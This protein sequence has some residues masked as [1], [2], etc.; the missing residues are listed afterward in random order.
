VALSTAII[1]FNFNFESIKSKPNHQNVQDCKNFDCS[2][3][4]FNFLTQFLFQFA[5]VLMT[6]AMVCASPAPKADP[7]AK[8]DPGV[9]AYTAPVVDYSFS[10]Y[11]SPYAAYS[12]PSFASA[13][14]VASPYIAS[15][16][17][18]A[19]TYYR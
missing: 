1:S 4:F 14:Y 17:A 16:Y 19:Y 2:F 3:N 18:A 6:I 5:I 9:L 13:A 15:P 7:E 11:V 8:A 10:P 12:Y